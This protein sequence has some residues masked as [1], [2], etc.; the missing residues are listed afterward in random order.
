MPTIFIDLRHHEASNETI[1]T[2]AEHLV[3]G[4]SSSSVYSPDE[5]IIGYEKYGSAH[6][7]VGMR[8]TSGELERHLLCLPARCQPV[9][10]WGLVTLK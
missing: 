2:T 9:L 6:Y 3:A 5:W 7:L 10:A 8:W 1:P 4:G